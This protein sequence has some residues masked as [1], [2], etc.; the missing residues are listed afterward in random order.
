MQYFTYIEN[1]QFPKRPPLIIWNMS[2][3]HYKR[4]WKVYIIQIL[5]WS[6]M[7]LQ[8]SFLMIIFLLNTFLVSFGSMK[9]VHTVSYL[10]EHSLLLKHCGEHEGTGVTRIVHSVSCKQ[11]Q[12]SEFTLIYLKCCNLND[13]YQ[14]F[15][16]T[17]GVPSNIS[18]RDLLL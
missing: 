12:S 2:F 16:H 5:R 13:C 15:C 1:F 17:S 8:H 7:K 3:W 14:F 11:D 9:I 4:H 6:L 18:L 10:W